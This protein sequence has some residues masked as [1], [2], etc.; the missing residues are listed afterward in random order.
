MYTC[1]SIVEIMIDIFPGSLNDMQ[2]HDMRNLHLKR[3]QMKM[4]K[5]FKQGTISTLSDNPL[6]LVDQFTNFGSH[7]SSYT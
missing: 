1:A 4:L 5:C 2:P 3:M 7:T 6:E